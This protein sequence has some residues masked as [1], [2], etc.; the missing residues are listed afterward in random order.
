MPG[1]RF[2]AELGYGLSVSVGLTGTS[3]LGL[4]LDNETRDYRLGWRFVSNRLQSFSPGFETVHREA[5]NNN[6]DSG[7]EIMLQG[8]LRW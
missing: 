8:T 6:A 2:D 4:G 5:A 7:N 1:V 3:Y